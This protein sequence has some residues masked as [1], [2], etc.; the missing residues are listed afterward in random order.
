MCRTEIGRTGNVS[1]PDDRVVEQARLRNSDCCYPSTNVVVAQT[2]P[3]RVDFS[4]SLKIKSLGLDDLVITHMRRSSG[5][6]GLTEP[7]A[8]MDAFTAC[9]HL[10][11]FTDYDI[12][13]DKCHHSSKPVAAGTIHIND[14]RHAW[15]ADI[16]C[17]F[18]VVNFQMPRWALDEVA[19]DYN[20]TRI[21]ELRCPISS[22]NVDSVLRNLASALLPA[23]ARPEPATRLF[24][25]YSSRA[26]IGHLAR[27]Y[28]TSEYR[29]GCGQGGLAPWQER[30]V[31]DLLLADLSANPGL[32]E[33]ASACRLSASQFSQAFKHTV[34]CPPHQWLLSQR[35]DK[36]KQL[37]LNTHQ[38]LSDIALAMG[39]AD[40]SHF[41]RIFSRRVKMSPAA[42]RRAHSR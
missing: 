18:Q 6:H 23:L 12:W 36:A 15:Q 3:Q 39:F 30:R 16:R 10:D 35:V 28:G 1:T 7:Q 26:V 14:M 42:W 41:C 29:P 25:E 21:D 34:G 5:G 19:D 32:A 2:S 4:R 17:P 9:V 8:R 11:E 37:I 24:V 31:K 20:M 33:L 40:Q 38:P 22:G 27:T 13:C